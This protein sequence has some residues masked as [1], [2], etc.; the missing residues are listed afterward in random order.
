MECG[1]NSVAE[2][3]ESLPPAPE[4]EMRGVL[5]DSPPIV[6]QWGELFRSSYRAYN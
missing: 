1:W 5:S 6:L 3:L 4:A 2:Q